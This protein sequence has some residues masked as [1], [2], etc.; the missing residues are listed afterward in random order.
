LVETALAHFAR[1]VHAGFSVE[2][3]HR[4]NDWVVL[5]Q[6]VPGHARQHAPSGPMMALPQA[7]KDQIHLLGGRLEFAELPGD[8]HK[9]FVFI[10]VGGS[11]EPQPWPFDDTV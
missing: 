10:G 11:S 6:S 5:L 8:V 2:L 7:F 3:L 4:P 9:A 1:Y